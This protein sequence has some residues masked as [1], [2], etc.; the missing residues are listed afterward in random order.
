MKCGCCGSEKLEVFRIS[1][2]HEINGFRLHVKDNK[3]EYVNKARVC[4][5]CGCVIP[6]VEPKV[7][8]DI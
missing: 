2:L 8:T 1:Q 5:E 6:F 3:V 7:H 4:K